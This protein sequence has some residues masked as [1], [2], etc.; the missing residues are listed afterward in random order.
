MIEMYHCGL[1]NNTEIY[2]MKSQRLPTYSKNGHKVIFDKI[3]IIIVNSFL[4]DCC[5]Y[6]SCSLL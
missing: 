4:F 1:I 6:V 3:F 5:I 2:T